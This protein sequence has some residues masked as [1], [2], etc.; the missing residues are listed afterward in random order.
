MVPHPT[1]QTSWTVV[2]GS[3]TA[4]PPILDANAVL[5]PVKGQDHQ[6]AVPYH[7]MD[8]YGNVIEHEFKL[9]WH[10]LLGHILMR[11]GVNEVSGFVGHNRF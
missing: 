7:W 2:F 5:K 11:P 8:I 6:T 4:P 3:Q 1:L 9:G 10:C